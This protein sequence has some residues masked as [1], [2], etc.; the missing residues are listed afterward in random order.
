VGTLPLAAQQ[1]VEICRA[2]AARARIV[3]MDEP[4]SSLQRDDVAHLFTL[5]RRLRAE[6]LGIIYIS[7]F[8]EEVR[9]IADCVHRPARRQ[10]RGARADWLCH[11]RR[12]RRP[13]GGAIR[14]SALP[15]ARAGAG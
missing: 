13:H 10:Q 12:P 3:L 7:H 8:L 4:T 9:E 2:I 15:V 1:V 5:I 14:R 6:G 11:Q